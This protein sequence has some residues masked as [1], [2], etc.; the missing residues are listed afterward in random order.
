LKSLLAQKDGPSALAVALAD[1][2][3]MPDTA[4]LA[5]RVVHASLTPSPELVEAVQKAGGIEAGGGWKLTDQLLQELVRE[6]QEQGDPARGELVF[7]RGSSQ[8]LKCHASGGA[9]G[10]VGPDLVSI[11]ASA[12]VDYLV[13]SLIEPNK[14]VKE[15]YHSQTVITDDGKVYNGIPVRETGAELVLRDADD[16]IVTIAK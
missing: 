16:R 2:K 5:L 1:K 7:R 11:G 10:V 6:A 9:G 12:P 14:K 15:N 13:E 8:C 4:K 3:L